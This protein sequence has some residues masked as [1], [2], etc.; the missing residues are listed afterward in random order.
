MKLTL[1]SRVKNFSS[2]APSC[3]VYFV[4]ERATGMELGPIGVQETAAFIVHAVN[5][6][7]PLVK[8]L[9]IAIRRIRLYLDTPDTKGY[10]VAP[11]SVDRVHLHMVEAVL[12]QA[13]GGDLCPR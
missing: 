5:F 6:Y 9:D 10:V 12:K 3:M 13:Q 2:G 11:D 4:V 8:A 7:S 1:E